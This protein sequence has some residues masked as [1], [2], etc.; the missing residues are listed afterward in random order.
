MKKISLILMIFASL[1]QLNANS[2]NIGGGELNPGITSNRNAVK[3]FENLKFG[4]S[5]HWGP[6]SLKGK[7][8]SWSRN[9]EIDVSTYDNLYKSFNPI[10][11]NANEWIQL[12][13]DAGMKYVVITAK[14]HDGFSLWHSDFSEYDMENT[15]F[16]RD[17]CRELSEAC[18]ANGIVFGTYYSTLDFYHPDYPTSKNTNTNAMFPV[19]PDT[20]NWDR[21]CIYMKNQLRELIQNYGSQIIQFDG[22]W[23]TALTHQTGSDLY[24]YLRKIK[25]DIVIN[26]RTDRGRYNEEKDR[27][28]WNWKKYA[29]DY[30]EREKIIDSV[31]VINGKADHLWQAWVTIDKR[32]WSWNEN[33]ELLTSK[34]IIIDLL[35]VIG[36]GGNYLLNV[37]PRSDGSFEPEQVSVLKEVGKFVNKYSD[38]I[39]STEGGPFNK[40]GMYASAKKGN[41]IFLFTYGA[42]ILDISIPIEGL[43]VASVTDYAGNQMK[44][45]RN[46]LEISFQ[47][48]LQQNEVGVYV[49]TIEN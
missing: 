49:L 40:H 4:L 33:P 8:I 9:R 15:P 43:K 46:N 7:E 12:M 6:S 32:Q 16:K 19:Y 42:E 45:K 26:N 5:I 47:P 38:A 22:D 2:Q 41:K 44:C 48:E 21:Y 31:T 30:E 18:K 25:D 29:G 35:K 1:I 28:I 37:G 24:L 34:E 13:K 14:H 39:F 10:R 20:P 27:G 11:F 23:D 36:E 3:C 17:I